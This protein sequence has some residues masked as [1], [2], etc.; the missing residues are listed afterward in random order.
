MGCLFISEGITILYP[1]F[2]MAVLTF[3]VLLRLGFLRLRSVREKTLPY[4]YYQVPSAGEGPP[5]MQQAVRNYANLH[6]APLLFY[7]V[8]IL[9]FATAHV[10]LFAVGLAWAFVA[11]RIVHSWIHLTNNTVIW[12]FSFFTLGQLC[13]FALWGLLICRV[14]GTS[15]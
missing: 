11:A 13:L 8:A 12:R 6:E 9:F 15:Y 14:L 5:A 1:V 7:V 10:D 2:A 4:S 3:M